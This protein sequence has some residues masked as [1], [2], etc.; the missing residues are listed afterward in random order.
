VIAHRD[1]VVALERKRLVHLAQRRAER[2]VADG[3]RL[4][5]GLRPAGGRQRTGGRVFQQPVADRDPRPQEVEPA[6]RGPT[7]EVPLTVG[8]IAQHGHA[9]AQHPLGKQREVA[10]R[11]G[12]GRR[13]G[14]AAE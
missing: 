3:A 11:E 4:H 6:V 1:D 13:L 5:P 12:V 7:V 10:G 8:I 14:L 9:A 2:L